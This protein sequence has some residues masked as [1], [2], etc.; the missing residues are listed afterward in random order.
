MRYVLIDLKYHR[1][2]NRA[3]PF[4]PMNPLSDA[5]SC[6]IEDIVPGYVFHPQEIALCSFYILRP[7]ISTKLSFICNLRMTGMGMCRAF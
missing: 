2:I 7:L 6:K 4:D 5:C 3:D 1:Q